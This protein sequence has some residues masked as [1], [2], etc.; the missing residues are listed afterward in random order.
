MK[1]LKLLTNIGT[2]DRDKLGLKE[3]QEGKTVSVNDAVAKELLQ[4]GWASEDGV[5]PAPEARPPTRQASD[6]PAGVS[7]PSDA[8]IVGGADSGGDV[9]EVDDADESPVSG[10][11]AGDAIDQISRMKSRDKLQHIVNSDPR[12]TVKKAAQ[13][14]LGAL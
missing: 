11:N 12:A 8:K 4:R 13:D 5:R 9:E 3:T 2:A 1:R 14:R 10:D 6:A 7:I